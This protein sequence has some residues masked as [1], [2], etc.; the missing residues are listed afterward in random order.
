MKVATK[1]IDYLDIKDCKYCYTWVEPSHF[2]A[3]EKTYYS[4]KLQEKR[5]YAT[6]PCKTSDYHVCP[7]IK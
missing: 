3:L 2:E 1:P 6:C 5:I 4:C 7:L